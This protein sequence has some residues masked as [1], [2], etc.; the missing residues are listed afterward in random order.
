MSGF[1]SQSPLMFFHG[2]C[3]SYP[4]GRAGRAKAE[5]KIALEQGGAAAATL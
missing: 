5:Q 3:C 1:R 2:C 4:G